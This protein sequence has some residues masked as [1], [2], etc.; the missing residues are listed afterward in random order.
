MRKRVIQ[1]RVKDE[2]FFFISFFTD[3]LFRENAMLS[4]R[5]LDLDPQ[6][7]NSPTL[8]L[9]LFQTTNNNNNVKKTKN[10]DYR[11]FGYGLGIHLIQGEPVSR[12]EKIN[13]RGD[14]LSFQVC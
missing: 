8:S 11:L 2:A 10:R 13:P 4:R 6:R 12:P 9:F 1:S 7:K 3:A 14:H 5:P